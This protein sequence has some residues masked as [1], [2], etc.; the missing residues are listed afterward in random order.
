M[1][2]ITVTHD[3]ILDVGVTLVNVVGILGE[4]SIPG[5]LPLHVLELLASGNGNVRHSSGNE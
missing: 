4:T 5:H 1:T 2:I 3:E